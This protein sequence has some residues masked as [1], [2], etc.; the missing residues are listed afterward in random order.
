M[1]GLHKPNRQ[2]VLPF[3]QIPHLYA[4]LP[5]RK[6]KSLGGKMGDN[7]VQTLGVSVMADLERFSESE[8]CQKFDHKNG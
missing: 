6:V 2:T 8:L 5:V 7:L 1:C 4:T 3:S